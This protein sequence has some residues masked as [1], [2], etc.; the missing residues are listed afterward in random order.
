MGLD[1]PMTLIESGQTSRDF[2][3]AYE[4]LAPAY[5]AFTGLGDYT[6]WASGLLDEVARHGVT[7]GL[8]VEVGCGTGKTTEALLAAGFAVHAYDPSPA[9]LARARVRVGARAELCDGA[10]PDLP[11]GPEGQL[12]MALND[13]LNYVPHQ[14]LDA[15]VAALAARTAPGGV[16]LFDV[17]T[18]V[19]YEAGFAATLF[20]RRAG[21]HLVVCEPVPSDVPDVY[22]FDLH[23]FTPSSAS[24]EHCPHAISSHRHFHHRHEAVVHALR[25]A[26][27]QPLA[28][29]GQHDDGRRDPDFD[30][31][32]HLKRIY[33]ARRP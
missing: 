19:P 33:L 9:M 27:L 25:A 13:V 29:L 24:G 30:E 16:V 32:A 10:L 4:R 1:M 26:G 18:A 12:V 22:G 20:A 23:I 15:A 5:D 8:A 2:V 14:Q 7:G 17:N 31:G 11:D 28:T 21:A 3:I 6:A